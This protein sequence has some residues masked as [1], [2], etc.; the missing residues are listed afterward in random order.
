MEQILHYAF[1]NKLSVALEENPA[2]LTDALLNPKANRDRMMQVMFECV[3]VYAVYMA[4]PFVLYVSGR[5]TGFVM[6]FGDGVS[7][8][9]AHFR[10]L[11]SA[12]RQ[13]SF[14]FGWP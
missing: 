5:T 11:R 12:S 1:C 13:T 8:T 6:D 7:H 10:R 14:G 3:N 9:N 4:S 2:L